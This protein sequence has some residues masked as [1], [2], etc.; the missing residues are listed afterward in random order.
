M[1][2][3][4]PPLVCLSSLGLLALAPLQAATLSIADSDAGGATFGTT[5]ING[6]VGANSFYDNGY[7]GQNVVAANAAT[8]LAVLALWFAPAKVTI[9][10][11]ACGST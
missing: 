7:Y 11:S 2:F 9:T 5:F 3:P 10:F 4:C 1:R 6:L 8:T